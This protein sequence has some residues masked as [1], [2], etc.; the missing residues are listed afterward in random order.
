MTVD[1]SLREISDYL[2]QFHM[3]CQQDTMNLASQWM[4]VYAI[5]N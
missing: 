5:Y 3:L 1:L 4:A 2:L